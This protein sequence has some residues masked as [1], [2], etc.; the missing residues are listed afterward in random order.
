MFED[1]IEGDK[2]RLKAVVKDNVL[3]VSVALEGAMGL[4]GQIVIAENVADHIDFIGFYDQ[5][6][7]IKTFPWF[8]EVRNWLG[9]RAENYDPG[10]TFIYLGYGNNLFVRNDVF[11]K[12]KDDI[13]PDAEV[14]WLYNNWELILRRRFASK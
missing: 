7:L 13:D 11:D 9:G 6:K 14:G 2:K 8:D 3:A 5:D 1:F 4:P 12:I 10:W